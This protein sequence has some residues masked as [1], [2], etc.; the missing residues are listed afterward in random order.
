V[1]ATTEAALRSQV[2]APVARHLAAIRAAQL[3]VLRG[4]VLH[5]PI[6]TNIDALLSYLRVEDG[7]LA[8]ERLRIIFLDTQN[9]LIADEV[10][11]HGSLDS[12]PV[13]PREIMRRALELG[14]GAI[15]L[16]HNHPSGD[17][18]PSAAD[19]DATRAIDAAARVFKIAVHDH[20]IVARSGWVSLRRQ[21][22]PA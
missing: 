12:A 21:G 22:W 6:L 18:T 16:T 20:L 8:S 14:A 17:P 10:F 13:F 9:R 11:G 1:L 5:A 15:I 4:E 3:S 7:H 19:L 2:S